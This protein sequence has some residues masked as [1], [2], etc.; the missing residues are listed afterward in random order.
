MYVKIILTVFLP[1]TLE[2][3]QFQ[4][5]DWIAIAQE[6]GML[7][8][9]KKQKIATAESLVSCATRVIYANKEVLKRALE[10][11]PMEFLE[12]LPTNL[13]KK[14]DTDPVS[15]GSYFDTET[16]KAM[17]AVLDELPLERAVRLFFHYNKQIRY[18]IFSSERLKQRIEQELIETKQ[19]LSPLVLR[20]LYYTF[21]WQ[22]A[23]NNPLRDFFPQ[24]VYSHPQ[25]AE[26]ARLFIPNGVIPG[27]LLALH[28]HT[29]HPDTEPHVIEGLR[30]KTLQRNYLAT[31]QTLIG[32]FRR[33]KQ[34]HTILLPQYLPSFTDFGITSLVPPADTI[35]AINKEATFL[36]LRLPTIVIFKLESSKNDNYLHAHA[37]AWV[38]YPNNSK[39]LDFSENFT[40][41]R[42]I[43]IGKPETRHYLLPKEYFL[44]TLTLEQIILMSL[45]SA[46]FD[47]RETNFFLLPHPRGWKDEAASIIQLVYAFFA[48]VDHTSML[49]KALYG[50]MAE[51]LALARAHRMRNVWDVE[52]F[53]KRQ[54]F[55]DAASIEAAKPARKELLATY[56][57]GDEL[58]QLKKD[59]A[60]VSAQLQHELYQA[61]Q[62][63]IMDFWRCNPRLFLNQPSLNV[64]ASFE[65][66]PTEPWAAAYT[67]AC[68][69]LL[70]LHKVM[71]LNEFQ[72]FVVTLLADVVNQ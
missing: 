26:L 4:L 27:R 35:A 62:R 48:K 18:D 21:N 40:S 44:G 8:A 47:Y 70:S 63:K 38:P 7:H 46:I 12:E 11:L 36:A 15:V 65:V 1:L 52:S 23:R 60:S 20:F 41:L 43:A 29:A 66:A 61:I 2:A 30:A 72:E 34:L 37:I 42:V 39:N 24:S 22:D 28:S 5:T 33:A 14:L 71:P 53:K 19:H 69:L 49:Y 17:Q 64:L 68:D 3:A 16:V 51:K 57:I 13:E 31:N 45:V 59:L 25:A 55:L 58:P 50:T 6:K 9:Q 67:K 32:I 10:V 54:I 56:F